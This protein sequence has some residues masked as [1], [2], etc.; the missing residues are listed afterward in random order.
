MSKSSNLELRDYVD[1]LAKH[2]KEYVNTRFTAIDEAVKLA[3][4]AMQIRLEHLNNAQQ[5]IQRM[6]DKYPNKSDLENLSQRYELQVKAYDE[7]IRYLRESKAEIAG[8]AS[9]E[10]VNV[11]RETVARNQMIAMIGISISLLS[12]MCGSVGMLTA[13]IGIGLRFMGL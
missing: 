7:D 1:A 10:S 13:V 4:D 12:L 2:I 8:K 5:T 11:V 6:G 9:A 3:N